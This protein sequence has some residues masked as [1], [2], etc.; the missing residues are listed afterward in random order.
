MGVVVGSK[1]I[2]IKKGSVPI[3]ITEKIIDKSI[4]RKYNPTVP[5]Y[6]VK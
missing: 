6:A 4:N 5:L 3:D 1:M 2:L